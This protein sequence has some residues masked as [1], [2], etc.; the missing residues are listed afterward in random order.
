MGK[1]I[2]AGVDTLEVGF[3]INGYGLAESEWHMLAE[4][5]EMAKSGDFN[6]D[7]SRIDFRGQLFAVQP[8]GTRQHQYRLK[9][10]DITLKIKPDPNGGAS[11]PEVHVVF[12]S[13]FLWQQ[14]YYKAYL[15]V[16]NWISPWAFIS[17]EK[18]S[19]ADIM[20]DIDDSLPHIDRDFN[21]VVTR[22]QKKKSFLIQSFAK[23]PKLTGYEFG[24]GACLCR[25]YDKVEEIKTKS[26]KE[27]FYELWEKNGYQKG[28][29]V[30]RIE[31]QLRRDSLRRQQVD[32]IDD[33]FAQSGDLWLYLTNKWLS[34][35]DQGKDSNRSRW[36]I[37]PYWDIVQ[38]AVGLFGEI[39]GVIRVRQQKPNLAALKKQTRGMF[40]TMAA[41]VGMSM[42]GK[43][44]GS[45]GK[46]YVLQDFAR[47][48]DDPFFDLDV[49][50]R[51]AKLAALV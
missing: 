40:V 12:S 14:G 36:T 49:K 15:K 6:T 43:D 22:A 27:W 45:L 34:L 20:V 38:N 30:T 47:T 7:G 17:A 35:R 1:V 21:E 29:P 48:F 50:R 42:G 33:L 31:F 46:Q 37:K 23:G 18:V 24:S 11:Y 25:V 19:R 39:T 32:T 26:R 3:C 9:N 8:S 28:A 51:E 4:A 44:P 2:L 16:K 41:V 5:K 10:N 13:A